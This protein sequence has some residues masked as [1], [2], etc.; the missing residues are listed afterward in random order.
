MAKRCCLCKKS[1]RLG[2]AKPY[3][4]SWFFEDFFQL[5]DFL[6]D[7]PGYLFANTFAFQVGIVRQLAHLFL[8]LALHFV[9]FA[10]NLILDAWLHLVAFFHNTESSL[11]K[12][13]WA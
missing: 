12:R 10:R 3:P 11:A 7:L 2:C 9:N 13:P 6:L 1:P 8:N 5:A 4:A